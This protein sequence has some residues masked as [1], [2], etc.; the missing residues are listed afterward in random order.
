MAKLTQQERDKLDSDQFAVPGKRAL[1]IHDE[2]HVREA[3]GMVDRTADLSDDERKT[4]RERI[5]RRAHEIG[6]DTTGWAA[7][8]RHMMALQ[9]EA[10]SLALPRLAGHPNQ[11]PFTGVMVKLDQP[12]DAPPGGAGGKRTFLPAAV[13]ETILP[14]LLGMAVDFKPSFDG[15]NKKAKIGLITAGTVVGDELR[16]EGFFYQN[17]F[18]AECAKIQREKKKLG[19]SYEIQAETE[20]VG[21]ILY[22]KGGSFTGA[23]VLY[24]TK[25]A[26]QSTSLAA[27]AEQE[28][29]QMELAEIMEGLK[30]LQTS[31]AALTTQVTEVKAAQAT[32]L[33]A[34]KNI[35]EMVAPHTAG[36]RNCAAGMEAAGIGMHASRG[37]VAAIH[38]MCADMEAQ[39][40]AGTVPNILRDHSWTFNAA[41][42]PSR[43]TDPDPAVAALGTKLNA[44]EASLAKAVDGLAALDT[45]LV[46][47]KAQALRASPAPA[48]KTLSASDQGL[49]TR[50]GI[51]P[52]ADG[53]VS[54]AALDKALDAAG[55]RNQDAI[56]LKLSLQSAG[57]ISA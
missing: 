11:M 20:L 38:H 10:M 32:T 48:R 5:L 56:A 6:I 33:N 15:H 52:G 2:H 53:K 4:A 25:A 22:I 14:T 46:D 30:A 16:I 35:R 26:Y 31:V 7:P 21:D 39:A 23:A 29:E 41:A 45:K 8:I 51:Q 37:H 9:L 55:V 19:F 43:N 40:A 1:P 28:Q 17:D 57:Q 36:L 12:S 54:I 44:V 27:A 50:V 34:N 42:D 47:L 18:P 3:W 24:K 49:L 13:A